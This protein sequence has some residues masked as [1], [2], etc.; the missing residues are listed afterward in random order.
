MEPRARHRNGLRVCRPQG[1]RSIPY[2]RRRA[3]LRRGVGGHLALSS[4]VLRAMTIASNLS[5]IHERIARAAARAGRNPSDV[6]LMA[7]SKT[8]P[9]DKI[10]EA[11]EAGQRLFG[12]NRVQE[13]A[14]KVERSREL[15]R[16]RLPHDRPSAIQQGRESRGSVRCDR[17]PRLRKARRAAERCSREARQDARRARS[18]STLAAKKRRAV[19]LRIRQNSKAFSPALPPGR[20]CAFAG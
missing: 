16:R 14:E 18:R 12:E 11:Y 2:Q 4:S 8:Q 3:L 20:T 13:F 10:I 17:F 6:A 1:T 5:A 7:V 9:A 15:A 19:S